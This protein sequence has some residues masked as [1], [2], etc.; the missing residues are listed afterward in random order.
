MAELVVHYEVEIGKFAESGPYCIYVAQSKHDPRYYRV[1]A[2][3]IRGG[4]I[5]GRINAHSRNTRGGK[6]WTNNFSPW[7]FIWLGELRGTNAVVTAALEHMLYSAMAER[8]LIR[9]TSGFE[10]SAPEIER[11][12]ALAD[13]LRPLIERV[14]EREHPHQAA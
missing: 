11:I 6:L 1:G 12:I 13:G 5:S 8:Y 7:R 4:T 9:D 3:G 10:A 2:T 14:L